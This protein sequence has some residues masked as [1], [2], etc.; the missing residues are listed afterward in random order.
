[1]PGNYNLPSGSIVSCDEAGIR[2]QNEGDT[3][4]TL[5]IWH[6][7]WTPLYP[8][9]GNTRCGMVTDFKI[10]EIERA[11]AKHGMKLAW[12]TQ[13]RLWTRDKDYNEFKMTEKREFFFD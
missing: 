5:K 8:P 10:A 12:V 4:S 11:Q 6:D 3:L 1:M 13:L 9:H 7:Q 2:V